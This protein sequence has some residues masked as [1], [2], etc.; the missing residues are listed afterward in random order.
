MSITIVNSDGSREVNL[1]NDNFSHL[2]SII[3]F[4][5]LKSEGSIDGGEVE[6]IKSRIARI[7][8]IIEEAPSEFEIKTEIVKTQNSATHVY[9]GKDVDYY[10]RKYSELLILF[11]NDIK[12]QWY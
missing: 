1:S 8:D 3:G 6:I 11:Q 10:L 7:I 5:H 2:F 4:D 9:L 12:F